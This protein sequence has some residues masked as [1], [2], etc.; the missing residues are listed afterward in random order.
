M[1]GKIIRGREK[2]VWLNAKLLVTVGGCVQAAWHQLN[3]CPQN[4]HRCFPEMAAN[5]TSLN[6]VIFWLLKA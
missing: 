2:P 4:F 1:M 3:T 5:A 6:L